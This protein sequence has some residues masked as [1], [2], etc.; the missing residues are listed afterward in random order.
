MIINKN[1]LNNKNEQNNWNGYTT[2]NTQLLPGKKDW[3][4]DSVGG[5]HYLPFKFL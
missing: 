5:V 3:G 1:S 4:V 2:N